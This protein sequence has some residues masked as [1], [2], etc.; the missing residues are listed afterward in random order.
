MRGF[1]YPAA[2][3]QNLRL[4][5]THRCTPITYYCLTVQAFMS[6]SSVAD[7]VIGGLVSGSC[8]LDIAGTA[9]E[10]SF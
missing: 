4:N 8:W 10:K 7:D 6:V 9:G 3:H 2:G 5:P 1:E